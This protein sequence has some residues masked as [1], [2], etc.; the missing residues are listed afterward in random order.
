MKSASSTQVSSQRGGVGLY[1]FLVGVQTCGAAIVMVNGVIVNKL[2][3]TEAPA[4][5]MVAAGILAFVIALKLAKGIF[6]FIFILAALA[7]L[8][9]AFFWHLSQKH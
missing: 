5:A 7:L 6:K 3:S 8:V 4:W 2:R 9:G 1:L